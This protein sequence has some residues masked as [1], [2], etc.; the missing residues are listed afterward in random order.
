MCFEEFWPEIEKKISFCSNTRL[1]LKVDWN[2]GKELFFSS[3]ESYAGHNQSKTVLNFQ[4][5]H[6]GE[7]ISNLVFCIVFLDNRL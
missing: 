4:M 6:N 2:Q 1:S 3:N 7:F 5:S